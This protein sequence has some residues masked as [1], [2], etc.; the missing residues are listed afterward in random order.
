MLPSLVSLA[1]ALA[2][3]VTKANGSPLVVVASDQDDNLINTITAVKIERPFD[4]DPRSGFSSDFRVSNLVLTT[5]DRNFLAAQQGN[6]SL[7][8]VPQPFVIS[9]SCNISTTI[10]NYAKDGFTSAGKRITSA[11]NFYKAINIR[12]NFYSFC[13]GRTANCDLKDTLGQ[14][15]ATAYFPAK[16]SNESDYYA[17]PQALFKQLSINADIKDSDYSQYDILA[18]FNS[19]FNFHFNASGQPIQPGQVDFEFVVLHELTHGLGID[20]AWTSYAAIPSLSSYSPKPDYLAPIPSLVGSSIATATVPKWNPLN[21]YDKFFTE[22]ASSQS[23]RSA[24]AKI[25]SFDPNSKKLSSFIA[26]F[27]SSGSPYTAAQSMYKLVTSGSKALTFAIPE[28]TTTPKQ[29]AFLNTI[30][31]R[32]VAGTS[33]A[34]LDYNAYWQ[35]PDFLMIPAVQNLTGLTL[36]QIVLRYTPTATADATYGVLNAYGPL[37][38]G[39]LHAMGWPTKSAPERLAVVIMD[40]SAAILSAGQ[41]TRGDIG[42]SLLCVVVSV[43]VAVWSGAAV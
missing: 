13:G 15:A 37:T 3:A 36:D 27:Q 19:D 20:T 14:A 9:F 23:L 34:H 42:V 22:S 11:L 26:D 43:L 5:N 4:Y 24:A 41:R 35:T 1:L 31:N 39:M 33:I 6:L 28:T 16:L 7:Q 10:C 40:N 32:Y 2:V 25:F 38:V 17:Y 8:T 21:I 12:A 30:A 29:T 18:E